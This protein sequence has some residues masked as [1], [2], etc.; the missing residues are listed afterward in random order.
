MDICGKNVSLMD[1]FNCQGRFFLSQV[2]N[3]IVCLLVNTVNT[4]ECILYVFVFEHTND[5]RTSKTIYCLTNSVWS[6]R[7]QYYLLSM[8]YLFF[9]ELLFYRISAVVLIVHVI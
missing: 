6:A 2:S 9:T 7:L 4:I 8:Q 5:L 3:M 1:L